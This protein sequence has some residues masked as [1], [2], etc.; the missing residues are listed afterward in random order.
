MTSKDRILASIRGQPVDRVANMP[1]IKQFCARQTGIP[2]EDYN[3]DHRVLVDCQIQMLERWKIDCVNV[4]GFAYREAGDC[5]LQLTW[6][7]DAPPHPDSVLVS[8][9]KDISALRWPTPWD[10]PLMSDRLRANRVAA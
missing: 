4:T 5:G 2:F 1:L 9:W 7:P 3:R 6:L 10:G 8:E